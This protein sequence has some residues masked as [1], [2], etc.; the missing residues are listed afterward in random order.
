[1]TVAVFC[2]SSAGNNIEYENT[3]K[4]LGKFFALNNM[5]R[6]KLRSQI[7]LGWIVMDAYT[8]AL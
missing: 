2:G 5:E 1:M 3:T 6:L 4:E 8:R 7:R